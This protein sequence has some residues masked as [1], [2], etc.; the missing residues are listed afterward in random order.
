[1]KNPCNDANVLY[2]Y[3]S[4]LYLPAIMQR[5]KLPDGVSE[6]FFK[7]WRVR[8][9]PVPAPGPSVLLKNIHYLHP[10]RAAILIEVRP[11]IPYRLIVLPVA[12]RINDQDYIDCEAVVMIA[13]S[14][15][16]LRDDFPRRR[17]SLRE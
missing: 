11:R 8:E 3:I 10:V 9:F 4:V 5:Q 16:G 17:P 2:F 13:Q 1:M 14:A 6:C 15:P 7:V 12:V